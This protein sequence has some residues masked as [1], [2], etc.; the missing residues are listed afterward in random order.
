MTMPEYKTDVFT[1]KTSF[2]KLNLYFYNIFIIF[3]T[4][5]VLV[6]KEI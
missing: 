2:K 4:K 1:T 5:N 6:V 3:Y